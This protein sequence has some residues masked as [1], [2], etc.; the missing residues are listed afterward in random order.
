[1]LHSDV[2]ATYTKIQETTQINIRISGQTFIRDG[3][4]GE[5]PFRFVESPKWP[6]KPNK[7]H[8]E[9]EPND[10]F[11]K[12]LEAFGK[13]GYKLES[14]VG[15]KRFATWFALCRKWGTDQNV[16]GTENK[17]VVVLIG[18]I[19]WTA[20]YNYQAGNPDKK[21][22]IMITALEQLKLEVYDKQPDMG[23]GESFPDLRYDASGNNFMVGT[24]ILD[25]KEIKWCYDDEGEITKFEEAKLEDESTFFSPP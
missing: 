22:S 9:D 25:D 1:V 5:F 8:K 3:E 21:S 12:T 2:T 19:L 4:P 18:K 6:D 17:A 14:V 11:P 15:S 23:N 13:S 10:V 20:D 16:D 24:L 7:D